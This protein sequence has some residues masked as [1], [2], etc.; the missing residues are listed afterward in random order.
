V[1][2]HPG[3]RSTLEPLLTETDEIISE[4]RTVIFDLSRAAEPATDTAPPPNPPP[5]S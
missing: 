1:S 3:T 2:R 5:G 4:L